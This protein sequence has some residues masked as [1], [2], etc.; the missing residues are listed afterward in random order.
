MT[1]NFACIFTCSMTCC[2]T[3][4]FTFC[5][6]CRAACAT[7][8]GACSEVTGQRAGKGKLQ[9]QA[10][11][12]VAQQGFDDAVGAAGGDELVDA[13]APGLDQP[14]AV[15]GVG[16][17]RVAGARQVTGAQAGDAPAFRQ[18]CRI[19][20]ADAVVVQADLDRDAAGVVLVHDGIDQ[21]LAQRRQRQWV[22]RRCA[23]FAAAWI[24]LQV[25]L[26]QRQAALEL[27][28]QVATDGMLLDQAVIAA[29]VADA[30]VGAAD[31][32]FR[33]GVEQQRGRALEMEQLQLFDQGGIALL[34]AG[35]AQALAG[36]GALAE[37]GQRL[38]I[39][40][41]QLHLGHRQV[42]PAAAGVRVQ[43]AVG[44]RAGGFRWEVFPLEVWLVFHP[45]YPG[46]ARRSS[47]H[48]NQMPRVAGARQRAFVHVPRT[49]LPAGDRSGR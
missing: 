4:G 43:E 8:G 41:G 18:A 16:D 9:P 13:Q 42:V 33:L 2:F 1:C 11:L 3:C 44:G 31:Q 47:W 19:P 26:E 49:R 6:T 29:E 35:A 17:V 5:F 45:R 23:G 38:G 22:G 39:E 34:R 10:I 32:L 30:D 24:T 28:E 46:C 48:G 15:E 21:R 40:V 14:G 37:V 25:L 7:A 12:L 20:Q 36:R 27:D